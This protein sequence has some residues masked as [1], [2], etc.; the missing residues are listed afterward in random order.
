MTTTKITTRPT[1][2]A[3]TTT[4]SSSSSDSEYEE[5][6]SEDVEDNEVESVEEPLPSFGN[7]KIRE[8]LRFYYF[9]HIF[10][11]SV[12]IYFKNT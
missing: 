3:T 11:L 7:A 8:S 12:L 10:M 1:K 5:E 6:T 9:P 4:A 2:R